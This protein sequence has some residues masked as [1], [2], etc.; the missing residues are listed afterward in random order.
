M[1]KLESSNTGSG[2]QLAKLLGKLFCSFVSHT[3][4]C[5]GLVPSLLTVFRGPQT[6]LGIEPELATCKTNPLLP[7]LFL[8]IWKTFLEK[9]IAESRLRLCHAPVSH[10]FHRNAQQ[11]VVPSTCGNASRDRCYDT[12][13]LRTAKEEAAAC[14]PHSW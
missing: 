14:L 3:W 2:V 10:V 6:V 7:A 13:A 8:W 9:H 1:E 5:S 4:K 12:Y 11:T